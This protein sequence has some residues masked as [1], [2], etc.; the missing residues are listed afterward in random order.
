VG[1]TALH[2]FPEHVAR[3]MQESDQHV[4]ETGTPVEEIV[5][6]RVGDGTRRWLRVKFPFA[7]A[8]GETLVGAVALDVTRQWQAELEASAAREELERRR[9]MD[10]KRASIGR[11]SAGIAHEVNNPL[12]TIV[13]SLEYL[14]ERRGE[15]EQ[16]VQVL[17]DAKNAATGWPPSSTVFAPSRAPS[18]R[19]RRAHRCKSP[20][21]S[22]P[23][24]NWWRARFVIVLD[25]FRSCGRA[26]GARQERR[27]V[28]VIVAL[29]MNAAE[30]IPDDAFDRHRISVSTSVSAGMVAID[31]VDTGAGMTSEQIARIFDP[32]FTTKRIGAGMGLGL[33]VAHGI[34]TAMGGRIEVASEPSR[35][36]T[37]RVLLPAAATMI[38]A[39]ANVYSATECG[40]ARVLVVD[41]EPSVLASIRRVLSGSTTW[42]VSPMRAMLSRCSKSASA[43]MPS[44]AT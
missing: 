27:L 28:Q 29:L 41:D 33:S 34:V 13:T 32:F 8:H 18:A 22:M 26:A 9:M 36:S 1:K 31:V 40:R 23:R 24:C 38:A 35:G 30:A 12:S 20:P 37:F 10:D 42:S 39:N 16:T 3:E 43:S 7:D 11:L 21:S 17:E 6:A 44:S 19:N 14:I 15:S 5:E 2:V 25:S 4:I